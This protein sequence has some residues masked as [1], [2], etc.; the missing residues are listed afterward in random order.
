MQDPL[1][2]PF[3]GMSSLGT[4]YLNMFNTKAELKLLNKIIELGKDA[5]I[6]VTRKICSPNTRFTYNSKSFYDKDKTEMFKKFAEFG[7]EFIENAAKR[8]IDS[9]LSTNIRISELKINVE[10]GYH[11]IYHGPDDVE[12][13]VPY[14]QFYCVIQCDDLDVFDVQ[15]EDKNGAENKD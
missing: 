15:S 2:N 6:T 14:A 13:G 12:E 7:G 3:F 5:G 9:S 11:S 1:Y 4:S 8:F 10:R